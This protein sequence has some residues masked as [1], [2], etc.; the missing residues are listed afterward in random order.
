M[1]FMTLL[2]TSFSFVL[3]GFLKGLSDDG[4]LLEF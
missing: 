1:T 3:F 2:T 4:G